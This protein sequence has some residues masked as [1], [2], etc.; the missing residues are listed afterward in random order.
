[1]HLGDS[2]L[3]LKN[4][5]ELVETYE[6]AERLYNAAVSECTKILDAPRERD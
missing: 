5:P 3:T 6:L 2:N 1:M 4:D